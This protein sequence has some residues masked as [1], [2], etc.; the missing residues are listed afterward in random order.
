MTSSRSLRRLLSTTAFALVVSVV[1]S[2]RADSASDL[3]TARL[4]LREGNELRAKGDLRG[5]LAKYEAAHGIVF[6]PI[7]GLE[8]G[9]THM[10]LGELVEAREA[11]LMV[12]RIPV[13]AQ[14]SANASAARA[15]ADRLSNE[16]D[17][18]IPTLTI[19]V[20]GAASGVT[21]TVV[22]DGQSIPAVSIGG[23]RKINPG[24]HHV[25]AKADG[26]KDATADATLAEGEAQ[27]ITLTLVPWEPS[28]TTTYTGSPADGPSATTGERRTS[29]LVY[30]G[31]GIAAVGTIA[32]TVTGV[33]TLSKASS[34]K[35]SCPDDHCGPSQQDALRDTRTLGTI[36]TISFVVAGA[37]AA[38]GIIGLVASPTAEPKT[39]VS[40]HVTVGFGTV[41]LAGSFR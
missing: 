7:T 36:S 23:P 2:L 35:D 22:L 8:V 17:R 15:E 39:G 24:K 12:G 32:G 25:V 33:M 10:L 41:G 31:F 13:K 21:P 27:S 34:L 14:E 1:P 40:A 9:R 19:V 6:T 5:A 38:L 26:M 11:F 16:I 4:L 30:I 20:A 3:E 18:R 29:P 37:G 28:S